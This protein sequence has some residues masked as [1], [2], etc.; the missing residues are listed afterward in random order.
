MTEI[1]RADITLNDCV[2]LKHP[3]NI[4]A[5]LEVAEKSMQS[6]TFEETGILI[7]QDTAPLYYLLFVTKVS[8]K[9]AGDLDITDIGMYTLRP[10]V[11]HR[12][13]LRFLIKRAGTFTDTE[14]LSAFHDEVTR[15]LEGHKMWIPQEEAAW[16]ALG[17][18]TSD[19][20]QL[21][22]CLCPVA[23]SNEELNDRFSGREGILTSFRSVV[24]KKMSDL[25]E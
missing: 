3:Q 10:A 6:S 13:Y 11:F 1:N 18:L 4:F 7:Y 9:P 19:R 2:V 14:S 25:E 12:K 16:K 21:D 23:L 17:F 5:S 20:K 15:M 24:D 22:V 8:E